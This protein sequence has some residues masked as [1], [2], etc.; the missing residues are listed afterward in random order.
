VDVED[1]LPGAVGEGPVGGQ[2]VQ[3]GVELHPGA[4]GCLDRFA[5]RVVGQGVCGD[6]GVVV[7]GD[8][9]GVGDRVG[10]GLWLPLML[11]PVGMEFSAEPAD[12]H[13]GGDPV[14]LLAGALPKQPAHAFPAEDERRAAEHGSG[15][16]DPVQTIDENQR[17]HFIRL[18]DSQ[19]Q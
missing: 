8:L 9:E 13:H 19:S 14:P 4:P 6:L 16:Q 2:P 1:L 18:H 11:N 17:A 5:A 3:I 10:L 7:E 15:E 12:Q